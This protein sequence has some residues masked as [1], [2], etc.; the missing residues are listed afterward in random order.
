M[1]PSG[2]L[3]QV[4]SALV[5]PAG[6][7]ASCDQG[8]ELAGRLGSSSGSS[9]GSYRYDRPSAGSPLMPKYEA[10]TVPS[11]SSFKFPSPKSFCGKGVMFCQL[12][13]PL[14][15]VGGVKISPMLHSPT[16][17]VPVF[18]LLFPTVPF[19]PSSVK[20]FEPVTVKLN[21]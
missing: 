5:E 12:P 9:E 20:V 11:L 16:A 8:W 13:V 7:R 17:K 18:G 14:A 4:V 6:K 19:V 21:P 3:V 2:N 10:R 1:L 15:V